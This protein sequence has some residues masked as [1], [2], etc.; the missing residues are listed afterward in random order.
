MIEIV[1]YFLILITNDIFFL[2]NDSLF[3]DILTI[4][5]KMMNYLYILIEEIN[6]QVW[7][8]MSNIVT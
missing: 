4:Y 7:Y 6:R 5:N 3:S 1:R 2:Q 8:R